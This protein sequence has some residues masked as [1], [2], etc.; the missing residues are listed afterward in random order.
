MEIR[1]CLQCGTG[2]R[3]RIDKKFCDDQ[4]RASYNNRLKS[5][6]TFM[7]TINSI[8]RKNRK[9]LEELIPPEEGKTKASRR[10]LEDKGFN[11]SYHTHM[12]TTKTGA[13]YTFCYEFGFL[14]LEP[15]S[16][17][18]IKRNEEKN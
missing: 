8:I 1:S 17:M 4:C 15:D 2:L 3:G 13:T 10:R 11:F 5:D 14:S 6:T 7:R 18:L 12:Y 9:I 16:Y